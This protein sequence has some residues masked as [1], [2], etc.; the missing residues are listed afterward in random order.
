MKLRLR[1]L[2]SKQTIKIELPNPSST[3]QQLKQTLS[4][5]L[6]SSSSLYFSLNRKDELHASSPETT[7]Q[8]LGI[9]SGDLIFFTHNPAAFSSQSQS[10]VPN[11]SSSVQ[12]QP[13]NPKPN[14]NS[15]NQNMSEKAEITP[16]D[17]ETPEHEIS[18]S[19]TDVDMSDSTTAN[20]LQEDDEETLGGEISGSGSGSVPSGAETM[21]LDDGSSVLSRKKYFEHYFLRRVLR[22]ELGGGDG[23]DHKLM[24]I[25]IHAVLSE[26]GFVGFDS[27]SGM[28]VDGFHLPD[29]WPSKAFTMSLC[30]TLPE[31]LG[32]VNVNGNYNVPESIVLKFQ[33]MGHC[34]N[35]YGWAKGG[36]GL[37]HVCLN[38]NRFVPALE[39]VWVVN[40]DSNDEIK[41]QDGFLE[42]EV[43][44]FWK[45][46]KDGIAL[47]LLIDLCEKAGLVPPPCFMRLPT[48]LKLKIFESLPGVD[49]AKV[50]CVCSDLRYLSS[51]NELWKQKFEEEFGNGTGAKRLFNWKEEFQSSWDRKKKRKREGR[52]RR[53]GFSHLRMMR[54]VNPFMLPSVLRGQHDHMPCFVAPS[55]F[56]Q[57][58]RFRVPWNVPRCTFEESDD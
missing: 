17:Q 25:A 55:P 2:E 30:Y 24:V 46:V 22:E 57:V 37:H 38:E 8:S 48:E 23:S 33:N 28:R 10:L 27:V 9:T 18:D 43:F 1:S 13:P 44:E 36:S 52:Q 40:G 4:Q 54:N 50:G 41:N 12:Q 32:T 29:V 3:L 39:S 21:E 58:E 7:L 14:P 11:S 47:P 53:Q 51:S 5:S 15:P 20:L 6:S 42:T 45:I 31:L 35:I 26:S 49:L 56:R 19:E 16:S 34:I